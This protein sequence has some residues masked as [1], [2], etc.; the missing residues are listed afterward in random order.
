MAIITVTIWKEHCPDAPSPQAPITYHPSPDVKHGDKVVFLLRGYKADTVATV[1]FPDAATSRAC[2][3]DPGPFELK[4]FSLVPPHR[5]V[6]PHASKGLHTFEVSI[7]T[8]PPQDAHS[9]PADRKNGGIDVSSDPRG[10]VR[11]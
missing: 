6:S 1:T 8:R 9:P 3:T 4:P 7:E 2:F 5:T 10:E 11:P